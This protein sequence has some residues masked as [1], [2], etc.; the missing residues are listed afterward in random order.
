MIS[1]FYDL[2]GAE[3][4]LV[5]AGFSTVTCSECSVSILRQPLMLVELGPVPT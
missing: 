1:W 3:C 4:L 2:K 5:N